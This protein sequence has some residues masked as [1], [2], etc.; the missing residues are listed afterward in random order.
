MTHRADPGKAT[1]REN[2]RPFAQEIV[3][4][5]CGNADAIS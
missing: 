2:F 4:A 3:I 1:A 5:L